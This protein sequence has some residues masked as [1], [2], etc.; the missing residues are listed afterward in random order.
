ME[1][2]DLWD[3][4]DLAD[5]FC[6]ISSCS[7]STND[8]EWFPKAQSVSSES[9]D[10]EASSSDVLVGQSSL[11]GATER[12][13]KPGGAV[14]PSIEGTDARQGQGPSDVRAIKVE[15]VETSIEQ[16]LDENS[17]HNTRKQTKMVLKLYDD[18]MSSL[19]VSDKSPTS[20]VFAPMD[21][22]SDDQLPEN[23]S[24]FFQVLVK[25]NG[26]PYNGSSVSA[27][28]ATLCRHILATRA[29]DIKQDVRF[30]QCQK[31]VKAKCM[32]SAKQ[33]IT[34]G[35]NASNAVEIDHIIQA[36]EQGLL[37]HSNPRALVSLVHFWCMV[38][39]GTRA[40]EVI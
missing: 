21:S 19:R 9:D 1:P 26:E 39:F 17:S 36:F 34:P 33:G 18:T 11:D 15:A 31:V 27:F 20:S 10:P 32:E 5:E 4:D 6:D 22:T 2:R 29:I 23:L 8:P 25:K 13:A 3:G 24:K 40:N 30:R 16:F 7:N 14:G 35:K 12:K 38:G 28:Y 37:G